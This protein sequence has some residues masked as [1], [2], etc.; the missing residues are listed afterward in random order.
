LKTVRPYEY[1]D[2]ATLLAD[3]WSALD[4]VLREKGIVP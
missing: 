2:A 3:F 1:K 4:A